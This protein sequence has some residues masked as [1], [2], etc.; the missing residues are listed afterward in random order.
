MGGIKWRVLN[1]AMT[2]QMQSALRFSP[3]PPP[4]QISA[5]VVWRPEWP[6]I[7]CNLESSST[8]K[9]AWLV[10]VFLLVAEA[11]LNTPSIFPW[12]LPRAHSSPLHLDGPLKGSCKWAMW[13]GCQIG[14]C[15]ESSGSRARQDPGDS[16][17]RAWITAVNLL[18][19]PIG[20]WK[21]RLCF[22][23]L[24]YLIKK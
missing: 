2:G 6:L 4:C 23:N 12:E 8:F 3:S 11:W 16:R 22:W 10:A 5:Q 14:A 24:A 1:A 19:R 9:S 18:M 20:P 7:I 13:C 21:S 17:P 15:V